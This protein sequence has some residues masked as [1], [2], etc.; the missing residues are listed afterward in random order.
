MMNMYCSFLNVCATVRK[1]WYMSR[2][3]EVTGRRVLSPEARL[4]KKKLTTSYILRHKQ[5]DFRY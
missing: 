5:H 4:S 2:A 3:L 1:G